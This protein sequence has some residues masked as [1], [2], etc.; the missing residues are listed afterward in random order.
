M[1]N[2]DFFLT[3]LKSESFSTATLF[4]SLP[5]YRLNYKPHEVNRTAREIVE[6]ILCHLVDLSIISTNSQC[7][8]LL[9]FDF[10][11]SDSASEKFIELSAALSATLKNLTIEQ[12]ENENVEL[13]IN[14]KSFV[15]LPRAQMMWF[16]FFDI[17]HHRGQ[18]STYVRPM[19]GKV[20][21]IYGFS[22]DTI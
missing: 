3:C 12:W 6:H 11:D 9:N 7:D 5:S 16:F 2:L 21:A 10:T 1:N 17:I 19:G 18:L 15:T 22:A 14:G 20:P 8:E 13:L 4:K